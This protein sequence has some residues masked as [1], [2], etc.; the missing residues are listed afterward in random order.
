MG[1]DCTETSLSLLRVWDFF[2]DG[3]DL[4]IPIPIPLPFVSVAVDWSLVTDIQGAVC[5]AIFNGCF[6][7]NLDIERFV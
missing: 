2:S 6:V 3:L 5:M 7:G 1:I 4:D